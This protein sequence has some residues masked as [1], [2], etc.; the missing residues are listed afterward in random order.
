MFQDLSGSD[1]L[2]SRSDWLIVTCKDGGPVTVEMV[3]VCVYV[4]IYMH[5]FICVYVMHSLYIQLQEHLDY[6]SMDVRFPFPNTA[7][8]VLSSKK[9]LKFNLVF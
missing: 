6:T 9:R 8:L 1:P 5:L 4:Y 7:L 3:S 2:S